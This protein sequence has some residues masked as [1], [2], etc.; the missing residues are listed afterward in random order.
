MFEVLIG[1]VGPCQMW[2]LLYALLLMWP[3]FMCIREKMFLYQGHASA[4]FY[5][6]AALN[7]LVA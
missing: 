4:R 1:E 6:Q 7:Q 2:V 3:F 5:G